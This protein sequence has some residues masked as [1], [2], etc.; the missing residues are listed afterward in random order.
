MPT[1][2]PV[3]SVEN[4]GVQSGGP[5]AQAK[6][7]QRSSSQKS[8]SY[9]PDIHRA[10]PQSF[11]AEQGV[12][13]SILLSPNDVLTDCVEQLSAHHF[14]HP[15]NATIYQI[16]IDLWNT[17]A[18]IDLIALTQ[19]LR[20]R[21]IL[22]QVGGAEYITNLYTFV[23]TAANADFYIDILKEKYLLRQVIIVCTEYASRSY[24][25]QGDAKLLLDEVEA[26]VLQ[27]GQQRYEGAL[28]TMQDHV[29]EAMDMIE[30]LHRNRGAVSG[31][32][33]GFA[34]FD[35]LT[36]GLHPGNMVVIAARPSMG[37]TAFALNI[38]EHVAMDVGKAVAVFSLEMSSQEL[39]QR[40]LCSLA[41]VDLQKLRDG[42]LVKQDFP[43]L[44][45]AADR[46]AKSQIYIDDTPGLGIL[47]LRAKA[48]RLKDRQNIE[49][50]V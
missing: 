9:L 26:K 7:K 23:P 50:I 13:G 35:K 6:G 30:L 39:V 28:P 36:S 15:A 1:D 33:T 31:L 44:M 32:P 11:D 25:E 41:R 45:A 10:L 46:L 21:N 34:G 3:S 20:D 40:L 42:F 19:V 8:G 14:H 24:D 4:P 17:S 49:L 48:R 22:D 47:E 29:M 12:L 43:N 2:S 18:P 5:G 27:I 37:K 16:L 38:A